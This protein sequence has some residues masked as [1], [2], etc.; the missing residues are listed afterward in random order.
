VA[1]RLL[2]V[3]FGGWG[4]DW[5]RIV[6]NTPEVEIVGVADMNEQA[7]AS[8][9]DLYG[10]PEHAAFTSLETALS[11][12]EADAVL[13]TAGAAVHAPLALT[14]LASTFWSKNPLLLHSPKRR[15]SSR[16]LPR[17]GVY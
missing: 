4:L 3:G 11:E 15:R 12:L 1:L 6:R 16:R 7:L 10:L 2:H 9:R 5:T 17:R 8:A 14:A 13:I